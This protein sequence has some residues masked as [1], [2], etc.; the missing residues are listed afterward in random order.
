[1]TELHIRSLYPTAPDQIEPWAAAHRLPIENVERRYA[2][3]LA[4]RS[5]ADAPWINQRVVIQ[6]STVAA[7]V[8]DA[9]RAPRDI[10]L[11][12]RNRHNDLIAEDEKRDLME[13]ASAALS[14]GTRKFCPNF[15]QW[16]DRLREY[17]RV[18]F[19]GP[20]TPFNEIPFRVDPATSTATV[21]VLDAT[22]LLATKYHALFRG[23][24]Q[25]GTG[26]RRSN[27]SQDV[28]DIA[29]LLIRNPGK[30][31]LSVLIDR[32]LQDPRK[33][34]TPDISQVELF[35]D[36]LH[37][38]AERNFDQLREPTG[39]HFIEFSRAWST[40]V[41]FFAT[42]RSSHPSNSKSNPD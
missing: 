41:D 1:M 16:R 14:A 31:K 29:S 2:H 25:L 5:I 30:F 3:F 39:D 6:G 37:A 7:Y 34:W 35:N 24:I 9:G 20:V 8:F 15:D 10:D 21:M 4:L 26:A 33:F 19:F 23:R 12:V 11:L 38:A 13:R 40:V 42:A 28:F 18:E 32:L 27:Y 17:I 36:E 22:S